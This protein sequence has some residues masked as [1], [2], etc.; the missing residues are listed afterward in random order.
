[1]F[2][3]FNILIIYSINKVI[4]LHIITLHSGQQKQKV[5]PQKNK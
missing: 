2:F 5:F 4:P 3:F 1:V